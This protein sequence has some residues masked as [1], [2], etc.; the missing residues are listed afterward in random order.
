MQIE[1]LQKQMHDE[2]V[3]FDHLKL[4]QERYIAEQ[5]NETKIQVAEIAVFN[6]QQDIDLN[7]NGIPDSSEIAANALAQQELSSRM[8]LEQSKIGHDKS[9][10]EAQIALKDKEMKLKNELE[11]KKIEAIKVQNANQI[12]LANKKAKLD[13][14]MMDKK[15][16]IEKMKIASKPKT[17]KK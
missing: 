9:K 8:F 14:E 3:E 15:M 10:H 7:D 16:Q 6:K 1:Q 5:N 11:N 4:D 2:Q 13:R 12:E 17:P